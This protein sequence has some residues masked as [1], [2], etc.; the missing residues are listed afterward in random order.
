VEDAVKA[1]DSIPKGSSW[2]DEVEDASSSVPRGGRGGGR[3]GSRGGRGGT[4]G[5]RG[6]KS[7][8][9]SKGGKGT[10]RKER[11]DHDLPENKWVSKYLEVRSRK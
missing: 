8:D 2:A 7:N 5:G 6:G 1:R 10:E 4:R 9:N 3:G 11:K